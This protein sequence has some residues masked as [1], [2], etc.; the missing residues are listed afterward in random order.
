MVT[1]S[2]VL[3][4]LLLSTSTTYAVLQHLLP[5]TVPTADSLKPKAYL[6]LPTTYYLLYYLL[7]YL[8]GTVPATVQYSTC[9]LLP[10]TYEYCHLIPGSGSPNADRVSPSPEKHK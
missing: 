8:Y 9:N 2:S 10:T 6:L 3:Q 4:Y 7:Q 1:T 5:T